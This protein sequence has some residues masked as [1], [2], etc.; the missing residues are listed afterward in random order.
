MVRL[1]LVLI[2]VLARSGIML[3]AGDGKLVPTTNAAIG[4]FMGGL[5]G[6]GA[7]HLLW[8]A[9]ILPAPPSAWKCAKGKPPRITRP[10]E[11]SSTAASAMARRSMSTRSSYLVSRLR[12][13]R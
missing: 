10:L 1:V 2:R 11:S 3:L 12:A 4:A 8:P 6:V 13:L 7:A 9:V 5:L